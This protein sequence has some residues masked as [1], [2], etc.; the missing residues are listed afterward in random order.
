VHTNHSS[1]NGVLHIHTHTSKD[2]VVK[3]V[4]NYYDKWRN[5]SGRGHRC[6]LSHYSLNG[7]LHVKELCSQTV[8]NMIYYI[9]PLGEVTDGL[10]R[11]LPLSGWPWVPYKSEWP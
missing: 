11:Q 8:G 5:S 3:Q 10:G 7:V 6:S 4:G 1:L 2:N 9:I